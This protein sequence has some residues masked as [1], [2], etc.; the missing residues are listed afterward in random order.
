M[1][2]AVFLS[3]L[4]SL[5]PGDLKGK[6]ESKSTTAEAAS[7]F[8]DNMI[9]PAVDCGNNETFNVLLK[10]M[11]KSDNIN[12]RNLAQNIRKELQKTLRDEH[13]TGKNTDDAKFTCSYIEH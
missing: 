6:V 1:K 4:V 8:L 5:L 13:I 2:D 9:K 12:L 7:W 11:E 3:K 10:E